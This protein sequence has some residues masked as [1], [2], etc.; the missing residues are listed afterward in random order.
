MEF[1]ACSQLLFVVVA[2]TVVVDAATVAAVV[3]TSSCIVESILLF[4]AFYSYRAAHKIQK[5]FHYFWSSSTAS[6]LLLLF[7]FSC[8][9]Q[10]RSLPGFS[11]G[12]NLTVLRGRVWRW[13]RNYAHARVR[14]INYWDLP[15]AS[16][17]LSRSSWECCSKLDQIGLGYFSSCN[18]N[19]MHNSLC[20]PIF[21]PILHS[22]MCPSVCSDLAKYAHRGNKWYSVAKV[23][24]KMTEMT[25]C[26]TNRTLTHTHSSWKI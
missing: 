5:Y 11:V 9:A 16:C 15:V 25:P 12:N 22:A 4:S 26:T 21:L 24:A 8:C 1:V 20:S 7:F 18:C 17:L 13:Q 2:A 14:S 23:A 19:W 10:L 3:A 6:T